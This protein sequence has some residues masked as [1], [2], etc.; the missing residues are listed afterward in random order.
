VLMPGLSGLSSWLHR[1]YSSAQ[2]RPAIGDDSELP[3]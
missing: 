2:G 3:G 1:H